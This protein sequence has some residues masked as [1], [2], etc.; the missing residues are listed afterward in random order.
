[1]DAGT[2]WKPKRWRKRN[3]VFPE[4]RRHPLF[5]RRVAEEEDLRETVSQG[6][7]LEE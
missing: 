6:A 5:E 2:I 7:G 3:Q 1:M 4:S